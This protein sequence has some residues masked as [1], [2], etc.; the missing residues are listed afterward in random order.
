MRGVSE[1]QIIA[2]VASHD[3]RSMGMQRCYC[4]KQSRFDYI[5]MLDLEDMDPHT[6]LWLVY[7]AYGQAMLNA[8]Q[9]EK[10]LSSLL[11]A[12]EAETSYNAEQHKQIFEEIDRLTL[13]SLVKRF[14]IEFSPSE[15]ITEEL[16]NMLY[17][18]NELTHRISDMF[19]N[20]NHHPQWESRLIEE[21]QNISTY[22]S[23]TRALL[24][25]YSKAYLD[26]AG[27]TP[28]RLV[29]IGKALYPN[30]KFPEGT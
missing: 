13:G 19:L 7:A 29:T 10:K 30:I 8:H 22:F 14:L 16:D 5:P 21:I 4:A 28:E 18:R 12:R 6:R 11:I 17:F 20:A 26:R 23:E 25:P 1:V 3:L 2:G 9:L 24:D 27:L 15:E